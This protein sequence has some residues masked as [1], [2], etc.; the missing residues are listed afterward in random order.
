[1]SLQDRGS[2][3]CQTIS[4]KLHCTTARARKILDNK[5][6]EERLTKTS[7][8]SF[9]L[10]LTLEYQTL[11]HKVT[12]ADEKSYNTLDDYLEIVKDWERNIEDRAEKYSPGEETWLTKPWG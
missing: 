10:V 1:M 9:P 5:L 6:S 11:Q 8:T 12:I 2:S 7:A 4:L 3:F